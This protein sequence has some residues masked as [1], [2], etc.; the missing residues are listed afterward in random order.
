M[1]ETDLNNGGGRQVRIIVNYIAG[2][3]REGAS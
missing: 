1:Q 3:I 2:E